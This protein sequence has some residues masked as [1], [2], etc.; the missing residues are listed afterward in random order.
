MLIDMLWSLTYMSDVPVSG[1][2]VTHDARAAAVLNSGVVGKLI[3]CLGRLP[4]MQTPALRVLGNISTTNDLNTQAV[5]DAGILT[6]LPMLLRAPK[7]SLQKESAWV[8]SNLLAGTFCQIQ[9]RLPHTARF[10]AWSGHVV[11]KLSLVL[12]SGVLVRGLVVVLVLGLNSHSRNVPS[13]LPQAVIDSGV[14]P[15]L[16]DMYK[17]ATA[18]AQME[19]LWA[20]VNGVDDGSYR[21]MRQLVSMGVLGVFLHALRSGREKLILA[22]L[23]GLISI[24]DS[25]VW[26]RGEAWA[27]QGDELVLLSEA[28]ILAEVDAV[29]AH[30]SAGAFARCG[31]RCRIGVLVEHSLL[32]Q[33][34]ARRSS[35][36]EG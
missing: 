34:F 31:S 10:S 3:E 36:F 17:N 27:G 14:V 32:P 7:V 5:I 22:V 13:L 29:D 23:R 11:V 16:V 25:S 2:P 20:L 15:I 4:A 8:I 19:I 33:R 24:V 30:E 21:Q 35:G 26:E 18:D 1:D 12:C 6:C 28:G 9:V